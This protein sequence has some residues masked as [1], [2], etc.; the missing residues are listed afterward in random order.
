[1]ASTLPR[2]DFRR[3][4]THSPCLGDVLCLLWEFN[5]RELL[6]SSTEFLKLVMISIG[7]ACPIAYFVVNKWLQ[8]FAYRTDVTGW[9][10]VAAGLLAL[11]IAL[12]A[13]SYR[14]LKAALA[15]PVESLRYE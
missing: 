9:T 11:G 1:M 2:I 14:S 10:F 12:L 3:A 15:N 6:V 7:I 4:K 13:V 5:I 8:N